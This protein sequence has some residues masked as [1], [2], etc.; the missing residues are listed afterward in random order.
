MIW[1][2]LRKSLRS[3][4]GGI[5]LLVVLG[6]MALSVPLVSS[7]LGLA[8]TASIDSRSKK[9]I[10]RRQYCALGAGEYVNYLMNNTARWSQWW[11]DNP[12]GQETLGFCGETVT[13]SISLPSQPPIDSLSDSPSGPGETPP[14]P[15]YNNRRLQTT[16]S[17][18]PLDPADPTTRIYTI[19][20]TNRSSGDMNL[21]KVLDRLPEG[22]TYLGPTTGVTIV[23]PDIDGR[24]LTWNL[25]P[26]GLPEV[27][28]GESE[29]LTFKVSVDAG[30]ADGNY[31]NDAWVEAGGTQTGSGKTAAAVIGSPGNDICQ[32]EPA[33]A[34]VTKKVTSATD[35]EVAELTPPSSTYSVVIG[36]TIDIKNI[37]TGS[38]TMTRIRDL[39][40]L[41]FCFVE[42]SATLDGNPHPN[43][44]LNI[45]NG[46]TPCPDDETR[47]RVTWDLTDVIPS[48]GSRVLV[49]RALATVKAGDYWSDVLV[50][51]DETVDDA[52]TW[53]TAVVTLRDAFKVE[54]QIGDSNEVIG[55]FQVWVGT[56][57]GTINRWTVK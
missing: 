11:V 31:C 24:L 7:A 46:G 30:L 12:G 57:T 20:V 4:R 15:G 50:T 26:L 16:K 34:V 10:L 41:G 8:S 17:I 3:Q 36:Y 5:A 42:D 45:P 21:N 43:P 48:G 14:I 27:G 55:I 29:S 19:T 39:L 38:L 53:P 51:F 40:P 47:Q 23:P 25:S 1:L 9:Q 28:P 54:A 56:D 2:R 44:S 52:Y 13:L 35:F 32:N 18:D 33:A 49:F 37:G 22:F 6:F